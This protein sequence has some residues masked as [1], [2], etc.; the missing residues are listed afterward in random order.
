M[1]KK[2]IDKNRDAFLLDA[3]RFVQDEAIRLMKQ[4]ETTVMLKYSGANIWLVRRRII[5]TL[6]AWECMEGA[7]LARKA[8]SSGVEE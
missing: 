5:S 3:G 8:E 4:I 2:K 1:T 7:S 6:F